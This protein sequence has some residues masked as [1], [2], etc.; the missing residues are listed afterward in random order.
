MVYHIF[1]QMSQKR[2]ALI[3]RASL[4]P[5]SFDEQRT[6]TRG[7]LSSRNVSSGR[8]YSH[9]SLLSGRNRD[10]YEGI[11]HYI[12]ALIIANIF[13]IQIFLSYAVLR[14]YYEVGKRNGQYSR[15]D[16]SRI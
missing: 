4:H 13:N 8:A 10:S 15:T 5:L 7:R 1:L 16:A 14:T 6:L 9:D 2:N 3:K 11:V 12:R